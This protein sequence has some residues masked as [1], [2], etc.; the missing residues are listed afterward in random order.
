MTAIHVTPEQLASLLLINNGLLDIAEQGVNPD[1]LE[2]LQMLQPDLEK[3]LE[4]VS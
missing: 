3:L 2:E 1:I 4:Q